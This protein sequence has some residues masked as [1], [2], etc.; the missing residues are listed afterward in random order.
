MKLNIRLLMTV[1]DFL[2][3]L[4]VSRKTKPLS[5]KDCI[6]RSGHPFLGK[7]DRHHQTSMMSAFGRT[8]S[9]PACRLS[10]AAKMSKT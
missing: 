7:A 10:H 8:L 6:N 2:K 1:S 5:L 4:L 9:Q 3:S